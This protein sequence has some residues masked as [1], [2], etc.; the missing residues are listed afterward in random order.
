MF[1]LHLLVNL[2]FELKEMKT[3]VE[4]IRAILYYLT[5]ATGRTSTSNKGCKEVKRKAVWKKNVTLLA[6]F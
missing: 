6:S 2:M 3:G 1:N 4:Y 5:R